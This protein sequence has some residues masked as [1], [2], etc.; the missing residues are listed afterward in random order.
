MEYF[1][2]RSFFSSSPL[3]LSTED[4][5]RRSQ[6]R[7]VPSVFVRPSDVDAHRANGRSSRFFACAADNTS[8]LSLSLPRA[9]RHYVARTRSRHL[10]IRIAAPTDLRKPSEKSSSSCH[11]ILYTRSVLCTG[12]GPLCPR[13][14]YY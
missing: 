14:S 11:S 8:S 9:Q 7:I 6:K 10:L 3:C 2:G 12:R 5:Q 13:T 1:F 4:D